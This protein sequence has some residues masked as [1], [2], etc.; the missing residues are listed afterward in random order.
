MKLAVQQ[1]GT[2]A[3]AQQCVLLPRPVSVIDL[4]QVYIKGSKGVTERCCGKVADL[5]QF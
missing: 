3:G 5:A 4:C 1:L 2:T